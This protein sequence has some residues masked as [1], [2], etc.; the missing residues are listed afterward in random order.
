[1]NSSALSQAVHEIDRHKERMQALGMDTEQKRLNPDWIE[2][3][4][5]IPLA[6]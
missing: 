2:A 6:K 4:K 5:R 3:V 1:A